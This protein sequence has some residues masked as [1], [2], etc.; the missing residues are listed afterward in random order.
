MNLEIDLHFYWLLIEFGWIWVRF[1]EPKWSQNDSKTVP[2]WAQNGPKMIQKRH[3]MVPKWTPK[4]QE[5]QVA[6]IPGSAQ[7]AEKTRYGVQLA[8]WGNLG[9]MVASIGLSRW[10]R[11]FQLVWHRF[12]KHFEWILGGSLDAKLVILG[13]KIDFKRLCKSKTAKMKNRPKTP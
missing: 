1:W 10:H 9:D 13:F 12:L 7:E 3:K 4:R 8:C 2:K 11:F 6:S 5:G